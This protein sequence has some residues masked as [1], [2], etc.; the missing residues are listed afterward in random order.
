MYHQYKLHWLNYWV[1][2]KMNF[3]KPM[4]SRTM[5]TKI[6]SKL[7]KVFLNGQFEIH[8]DF[9]LKKLKLHSPKWLVKFQLFKNSH[10][11]FNSKLN[12]KPYDYLYEV[13]D[14]MVRDSR[15]AENLTMNY[16]KVSLSISN[17]RT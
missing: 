7:K 9:G 6:V 15:R 14:I 2:D 11:Q 12:S 8:L 3:S 5:T 16:I 1:N 13:T 17:F 10:V 4:I